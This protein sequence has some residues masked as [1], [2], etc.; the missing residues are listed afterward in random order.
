MVLLQPDVLPLSCI[1]G[2]CE[3][4]RFSNFIVAIGSNLKIIHFGKSIRNRRRNTSLGPVS[5]NLFSVF[6]TV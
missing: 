2:A 3:I 1:E 6:A 5:F 4:R